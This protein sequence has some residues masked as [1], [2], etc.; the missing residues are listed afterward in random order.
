[1]RQILQD[2]K[3]VS[4]VFELTLSFEASVPLR[5]PERNGDAAGDSPLLLGRPGE[6]IVC[7]SGKP[8]E[9]SVMPAFLWAL[10]CKRVRGLQKEMCFFFGK[11]GVGRE[12]AQ[13][14]R[15]RLMADSL[16]AIAPDRPSPTSTGAPPGPRW[17]HC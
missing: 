11:E 9:R 1:M 12:A 3:G 14:S 15:S 10:L 4:P 16:P 7:T 2:G 13:S 17:G 8:V 5:S 6:Q